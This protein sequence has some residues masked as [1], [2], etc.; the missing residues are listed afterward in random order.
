MFNKAKTCKK[1]QFSRELRQLS[2]K[3]HPDKDKKENSIIQTRVIGP[4]FEFFR[5]NTFNNTKEE[6]E[7]KKQ[8]IKTLENYC[9]RFNK[10]II[11]ENTLYVNI[12]GKRIKI[13]EL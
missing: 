3:T 4:L 12:E 10:E 13:N 1:E 5:K 7:K 2:T 8:N 9:Q 6:K 11:D